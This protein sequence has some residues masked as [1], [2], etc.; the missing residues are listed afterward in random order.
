MNKCCVYIQLSAHIRAKG[1]G[2]HFEAGGLS[3]E[4]GVVV[5]DIRNYSK[6][7][8]VVLYQQWSISLKL[9]V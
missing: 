8:I 6:F 5:L 9:M 1:I 3:G 2:I 7:Q 4:R